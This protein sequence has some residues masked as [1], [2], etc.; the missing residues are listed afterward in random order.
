MEGRLFSAAEYGCGRWP[1]VIRGHQHSPTLECDAAPGVRP[2]LGLTSPHA[3][4]L[5]YALVNGAIHQ[6]LFMASATTAAYLVGRAVAGDGYE[7]LSWLFVLLIALILPQVRTAWIE[8][9]VLHAVAFRIQVELRDRLYRKIAELTP[10]GLAG[11]RSGELASAALGDVDTLQY[12]FAQTLG[13][14]VAAGAAPVLALAGLATFAR[15]LAAVLSP[16][17]LLAATIALWL[18]RRGRLEQTQARARRAT[19]S[20]E[21]VDG[22]QGMREMVAFGH[23]RQVAA[24]LAG[25]THAA[26]AAQAAQAARA[27]SSSRERVLVDLCTTAGVLATLA[28]AVTLTARDALAASL[29]PPAAVL[30]ALAFGQMARLMEAAREF[31][32]VMAACDRIFSLLAAQAPLDALPGTGE[33]CCMQRVPEVRFEHVSFRYR[34]DLP[35]V[36][37]DVSFTVAPGETVALVGHS[38][39]GKSTCAGLLLRFWDVSAGAIT[40][41]GADV[42]NLPE[43][44]LRSLVGYLSQDP[45]LFNASI[46]DNLRLGRPD[47]T[48]AELQAAARSCLCN[49][50]IEAM[51]GGYDTVVGERGARLSGGQRQRLA[52]ARALLTD[53]PVLVMDEPASNLDRGNEQA[54]HEAMIRLRANRTTLVIAHRRSTIQAA[55]R[56]VVLER[57]RVVEVSAPSELIQSAGPY[58]RLVEP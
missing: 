38:G 27:A 15:L 43:A 32:T 58:A 11:R 16:F 47:A 29:L 39:A 22:M 3:G 49:E 19:L 17:L 30:A 33:S 37:D 31:G 20:S 34:S 13:P 55:A 35:E 40:I 44:T 45:Y 2:L 50:F 12:F 4:E 54:L 51:P 7:R 23:G 53:P 56:V 26:G 46:A 52:V 9:A 48:R 21:V 8:S 14:L 1:A 24:E 36:L 42:R 41:G 18:S 57:G 25:H 5:R 10:A 6:V 28:A